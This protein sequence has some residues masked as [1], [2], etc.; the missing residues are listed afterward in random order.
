M[1]HRTIRLHGHIYRVRMESG[2]ITHIL[3]F[4][5]PFDGELPPGYDQERLDSAMIS[6]KFFDEWLV[7]ELTKRVQEDS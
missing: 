2:R 4:G 6:S 1:T 3:R 5:V 7:E